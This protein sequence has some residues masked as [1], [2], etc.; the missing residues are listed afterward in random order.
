M[1]TIPLSD[2][3]LTTIAIMILIVGFCFGFFFG[4]HEYKQMRT[5]SQVQ[6][7]L[8]RLLRDLTEKEQQLRKEEGSDL[9]TGRTVELAKIEYN[10][11]YAKWFELMWTLNQLPE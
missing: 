5:R 9:A 7:R 2:T 8:K 10:L 1:N 3:M 4:A 6:K 11:A